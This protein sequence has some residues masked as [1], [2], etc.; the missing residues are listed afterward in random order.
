METQKNYYEIGYLKTIPLKPLCYTTECETHSTFR[1][2]N[3]QAQAHVQYPT[4]K[5][6]C[7][8]DKYLRAV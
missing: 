5:V 7:N 6:K 3:T 4:Y 2:P 8:C 1:Y